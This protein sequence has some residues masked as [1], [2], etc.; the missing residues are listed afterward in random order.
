M[1]KVAFIGGNVFDSDT[2]SFIQTNVVCDKGYI[3]SIGEYIPDVCERIYLDGK[4]LIS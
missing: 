3:K 4:Y 2:E 1:A